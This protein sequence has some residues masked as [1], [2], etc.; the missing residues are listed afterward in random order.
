MAEKYRI[1]IL[2]EAQRDIRE[3]VD[4]IAGE[5]A[6]PQAARR[7]VSAFEQEVRSLAL[8]PKR[9]R[10]VDEQPWRDRGIRRT[11]VKNYYVY[12]LVDDEQSAV[13]VLA[14]IYTGRDQEAQLRERD[15]V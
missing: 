14:M 9:V 4:Y 5:L 15:H 12:Y 7:L 8:M 13:Q 6:A 11:R 1:V 3:I 10:L 2:P